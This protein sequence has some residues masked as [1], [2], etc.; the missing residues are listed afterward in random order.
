MRL[1]KIETT[2]DG[3]RQVIGG[4]VGQVDQLQRSVKRLERFEEV[5][6]R[7]LACSCRTPLSDNG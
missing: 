1:D 7:I 4:L 2:F 3:M 6:S 5:L